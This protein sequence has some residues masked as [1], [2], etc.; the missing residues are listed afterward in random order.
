MRCGNVISEVV[1]VV[2]ITITALWNVSPHDS[3]HLENPPA[4]IFRKQ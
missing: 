2:T 1:T 3:R 4:S